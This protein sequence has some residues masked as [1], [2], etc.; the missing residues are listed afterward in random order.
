MKSHE[1]KLWSSTYRHALAI[2]LRSIAGSLL[3]EGPLVVCLASHD[4]ISDKL[5]RNTTIALRGR[6]IGHWHWGFIRGFLAKGSFQ[7]M[8]DSLGSGSSLAWDSTNPV[9]IY[10]TMSDHLNDIAGLW[11]SRESTSGWVSSSGLTSKQDQDW[12]IYTHMKHT[13]IPFLSHDSCTKAKVEQMLYP[14]G[15][16]KSILLVIR[17]TFCLVLLLGILSRALPFTPDVK[18]GACICGRI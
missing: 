3:K 2:R 7:T 1:K 13:R 4:V 18:R 9:A 5:Q 11:P 6:F 16:D 15:R 12:L 14:Q 10:Q 8:R 17:T